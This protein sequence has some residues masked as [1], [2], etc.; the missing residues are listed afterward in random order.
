MAWAHEEVGIRE[1]LRRVLLAGL[2][3]FRIFMEI[4]QRS[5]VTGPILCMLLV[6]NIVFFENLTPLSRLSLVYVKGDQVQPSVEITGRTYRVIAVNASSSFKKIGEL[7]EESY[8]RVFLMAFGYGLIAWIS[9]TLG[10]L[11][12]LKLL[13]KSLG[14][15]S[16]VLAGYT[17][18]TK[19][20]EAL[21]KTIIYTLFFINIDKIEIIIV[22]GSQNIS[23]ILTLVSLAMRQIPQLFTVLQAH[24]VFFTIWG[25]VVMSA[26]LQGGGSVSLGKAILG[27][28]ISYTISGILQS[29]LFSL[30][31]VSI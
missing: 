23:V 20:Y 24:S 17:L 6:V 30:F 18:S 12:G 22:P 2:N 27:A 3:P 21:T 9:A 25:L 4:S 14:V 19:F 16:A 10:V 28:L 15:S 8:G 1:S 29:V 5:D 31:M 13:G 26:A 11:L 7:S